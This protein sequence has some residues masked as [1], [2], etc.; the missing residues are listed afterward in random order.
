MPLEIKRGVNRIEFQSV[1]SYV[2]Y[3]YR[4][5]YSHYTVGGN[6]VSYKVITILC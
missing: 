6:K 2:G 3:L 1:D 4:E 5:E